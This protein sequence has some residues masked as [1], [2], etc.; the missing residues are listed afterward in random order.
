MFRFGVKHHF[1]ILFPIAPNT[2]YATLLPMPLSTQ[3]NQTINRDLS[4]SL[5]LSASLDC[6]GIVHDLDDTGM[7]GIVSIT[8]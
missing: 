2:S 3:N 7:H 8:S 4:R 6:R 1:I 5:Y